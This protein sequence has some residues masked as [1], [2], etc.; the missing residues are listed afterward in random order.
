M[1]IR[2]MPEQIAANWEFL[3]HQVVDSGPM[4][5]L[6]NDERFNNILNA[7]L[8]DDMQC[9]VEAISDEKGFHIQGIALTQILT[10][11]IAGVKNLLIYSMV[12]VE[13]LFDLEKWNRGLLTLA[14]FARKNGCQNILAYSNNPRILR[15]AERFK[16]NTSQRV[17][18]FSL[19]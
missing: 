19:N 18:V 11:D 8:I 6:G 15:L 17:I 14:Q 7:L 10:N 9:W 2:L 5:T 1:L 3:K 4:E 16:A 13:E 12:G